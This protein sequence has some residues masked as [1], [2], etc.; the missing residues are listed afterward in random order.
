[1]NLRDTRREDSMGLYHLFECTG[2]GN[3]EGVRN[4]FQAPSRGS[5]VI[6]IPFLRETRDSG[7]RR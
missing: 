4:D 1:M 6:E 3:G 7:E 2:E 5:Q